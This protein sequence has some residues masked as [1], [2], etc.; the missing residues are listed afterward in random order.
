MDLTLRPVALEDAA[1]LTAALEAELSLRYGGGEA[2]T[3]DAADFLPPYGLFLVARV[4]QEDVACGGLRT[5]AAGTGEIK[6]MYT[7]PAARGQGVAR[8]L[9]RALLDHARSADLQEVRL[10]TGTLQPEAIGLY[11]SEGFGRIEPYGLF[12]DEPL[13]RCYALSL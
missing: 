11:E 10:D 1:A 2:S 4:G 6:R 9:L 3:V 13:A 7:A 12:K 5:L 8:T